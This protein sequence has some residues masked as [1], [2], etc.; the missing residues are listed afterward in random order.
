MRA[1]GEGSG[2]G[3]GCCRGICEGG[4]IGFDVERLGPGSGMNWP[5]TAHLLHHVIHK[6]QACTSLSFAM[7]I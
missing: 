2:I 3:D 4:L 7:A 6:L 5:I 1:I